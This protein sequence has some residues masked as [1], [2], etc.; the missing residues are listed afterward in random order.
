M[1]NKVNYCTNRAIAGSFQDIEE[2]VNFIKNPPVEHINLVNQARSLDKKSTEYGNIKIRKL[3]AVSMAFNFSKD[4]IKGENIDSPTGYLYL[5]VDGETELDF[6]IN[7]TYVCARWRS[8][9]NT[10]IALVVKVEGLTADNLKPATAE[11]ARLLDIPYDPRAVSIDRLTVLPYDPNAYYNDKTD[12]IPIAKLLP[13][14]S[15]VIAESE[16]STH[17]NTINKVNTKGYEC[18][19]Y[20][21]RF[22]NLNELLQPLNIQFDENGFYDLGKDNKLKYAQVFIPF[23]TVNTG[24]RESILKSI[25]YQLIALNKD[26]PKYLLLKYLQIVNAKIMRPQ[27]SSTEVNITFNKVYKKRKDIQPR[28]S[29]N[30]R[31][32]YDG[33]LTTTEKRKLNASQIGKDKVIKTTKELLE[34]M[35]TWDIEK[36]GKITIDKVTEVSGKDKKTVQKYYTE[37]KK[38]LFDQEKSI[39]Q[40]MDELLFWDIGNAA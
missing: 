20:K 24:E 1:I 14:D 13:Y 40:E 30:R 26:A 29:T 35:S 34:I 33:T 21:L 2:I 3:P 28:L 10:G 12:I 16:K 9:S 5:D 23:R 18:N 37:L 27:L 8:L 31:F 6:E 15:E 36:Y 17:F 7:T 38:Q 22:N 19:G 11:I 25:A 39:L 32:F 4:Y